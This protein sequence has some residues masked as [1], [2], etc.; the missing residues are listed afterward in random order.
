MI[1]YLREKLELNIKL[2]D[3]I[4]NF[5]IYANSSSSL[6]KRFLDIVFIY[7]NGIFTVKYF[8][9]KPKQ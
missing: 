1:K 3:G 5:N 2:V 9:N 8:K 4:E 6:H 7:E